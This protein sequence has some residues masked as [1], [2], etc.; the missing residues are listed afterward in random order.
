MK[1]GLLFVLFILASG[2]TSLAQDFSWHGFV[3]ANYSLRTTGLSPDSNQTDF[4]WADHR[5]QLKFSA[6]E[7]MA[8]ALAKVDLFQN[9]LKKENDLEIREAYIDYS[10]G[11]FDFRVGRQ[12][13][14][15]GL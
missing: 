10:A 8:R 5:L 12:I 6:S 2:G 3:Q 4:L 9:T 13:I 1:R 7:G 14:T 11:A 15:W